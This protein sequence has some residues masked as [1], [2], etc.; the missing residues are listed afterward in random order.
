MRAVSIL[1]FALSVQGCDAPE[2]GVSSAFVADDLPPPHAPP[3]PASFVFEAGPVCPG[4][5]LEGRVTG[6]VPLATA[7][8]VAGTN[9]G[10]GRCLGPT[11]LSVTGPYK[12]LAEVPLDE[13]GEAVIWVDLD[14]AMTVGQAGAMQVVL[15]STGAVS[16]ALPAVSLNP[17]DPTCAPVGVTCEAGP[18]DATFFD[19]LWVSHRSTDPTRPPQRP[20]VQWQAWMM[21]DFFDFQG[22]TNEVLQSCEARYVP[23]WM[24]N[25]ARGSRIRAKCTYP[26]APAIPTNYSPEIVLAN[27]A[28]SVDG[29]AIS[30]AAPTDADVLTTTAVGTDPDA[31]AT[32]INLQW[33]VNGVQ[34]STAP[35]LPATASAPGDRVELV[36]NAWDGLARATITSSAVTIAP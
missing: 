5:I 17:A 21:Y 35:T 1:L 31:D 26:T 15:R 16:N 18:A 11:C 20:S 14:P 23:C 8:L 6:G 36:C 27:S 28:P 12:V 2:G 4:Q 33:L 25:C 9:V 10:Q 13:A 30:P 24:M 32:R 34:A 7:T 29:C 22:E 3:T 19:D